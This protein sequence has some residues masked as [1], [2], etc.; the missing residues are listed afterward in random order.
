M[1]IWDQALYFANGLRPDADV[2]NIFV[3]SLSEG[4]NKRTKNF[5]YRRFKQYKI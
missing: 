5:K 3:D 2:S 4:K 1:K